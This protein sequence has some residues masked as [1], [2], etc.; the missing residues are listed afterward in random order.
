[1][2]RLMETLGAGEYAHYLMMMA[3]WVY[4]YINF[5]KLYALCK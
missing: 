1:M 5:L 4:T 2:E 3:S